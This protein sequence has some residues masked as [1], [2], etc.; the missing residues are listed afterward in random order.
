MRSSLMSCLASVS[1]VCPSRMTVTWSATRLTSLSL[2]EIRIEVMP[3]RLNSSSRSSSAWL[4][5]SRQAGRRLVEDQQLDFLAQRLGDLDQLLLADADIG[6]QRLGVLVEADLLE[7]RA[8]AR[9]VGVPV[10]DA[11]SGVLVAEEDVLGDRQHRHQ[12][13]LLVDDDDA[14]VFAVVDAFEVALLAAID[15][16]AVIGAGRIDAR[17]HLHQ[18]RFAGAV[19]ADHGVDLAFL[20]AEID[21]RQRLHAGERLG[22]V[23][24]L[25]NR[26]GHRD[27]CSLGGR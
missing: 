19:L 3:C 12:R 1:M 4:S 15:D 21:V 5:F 22:D 6:D 16:L 18:R 11:E 26:R 13:K 7:Q 14:H 10:D 17:Q 23:A 8:G 9:L 25:Q 2:C 27:T 20:D 24:H